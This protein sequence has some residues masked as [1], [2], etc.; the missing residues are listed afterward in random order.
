MRV[1]KGGK[2][3]RRA[4]RADAPMVLLSAMTDAAIQAEAGWRDRQHQHDH[5][6]QLRAYARCRAKFGTADMSSWPKNEAD[7]VLEDQR[8]RDLGY[9]VVCM[10]CFRSGAGTKALEAL[11]DALP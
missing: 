8:K 5:A 1:I 11:I 9:R 3:S 2:R 10:R 7:A 6:T 4:S